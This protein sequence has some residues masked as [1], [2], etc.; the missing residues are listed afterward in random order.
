MS[1]TEPP[2]RIPPRESSSETKATR[3][4]FSKKVE[5]VREVDP[6]EEARKKRF[7]EYYKESEEEPKSF[8]PSPFDLYSKRVASEVES[9]ESEIRHAFDKLGEEAVPTPSNAWAPNVNAT[10]S[11]EG[12]EEET[13]AL[14]QSEKFWHD[15]DWQDKPPQKPEYREL[16]SSQISKHRKQVKE[17]QKKEAAKKKEEVFLVGPPGTP[18]PSKKEKPPEIASSPAALPKPKEPTESKEKHKKAQP[19]APAQLPNAPVESREQREKREQKE[20]DILQIE[21]PSTTALPPEIAPIAMNATIQAAPYLSS[22]TVSL[23]YQMVGTIYVMVSPPG[24]SRTEILLNN[25]SFA[26]SRFFGSTIT[27]EKYAT[28]PDSLNIRLTGSQEAVL[29]FK[30]HIPSLLTAFQN[31]RF[32]FRIG[33]LDAEYTLDRPV[34]RRKESGSSKGDAG[35]GD[36]GERKQQ[37]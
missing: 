34:F 26:N 31:G 1:S 27:I 32:S 37:R 10:P 3:D 36:L 24:I 18:V 29:L 21:P 5:K 2:S 8:H 28:A 15:S 7:A 20:R 22:A 17:V 30:E 33:R 14:P 16:P 11:E 23:F 25:P 19:I 13:S 12:D 9:V 35:G 6:D 4:E